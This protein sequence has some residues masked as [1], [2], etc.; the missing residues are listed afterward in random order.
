MATVTASARSSAST[1]AGPR[2]RLGE[3]A[4]QRVVQQPAEA[5]EP[6][7]CPQPHAAA[8]L[9]DPAVLVLDEPVN[10]LDPEGIL[11]LRHLV[12]DLA[13][14]GR[15]VFVS[16]HLMSEAALTV[17][18]L[19]IIGRGRLLADTGMTAFIDKYTEVGVRV[20]TPEPRRLRDVLAGAGIAVTDCSDGSLKVAAAAERIGELVAAHAVTVHE[21]TRKTVSLEKAFMRLTADAVEYRA[22][23]S[24][25]CSTAGTCWP[26]RW[27][28][29]AARR[30]PSS[31]RSPGRRRRSA[32]TASRSLRTGSRPRLPAPLP[33]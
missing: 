15:T 6:A 18:H 10:G 8:L 3:D 25:G 1:T 29:S 33:T 28:P 31:S 16:S 14:Q 7:P 27:P 26:A 17:D 12:R 11:W 19:V 22:E 20:R 4:G 5:G 21:V 30:S 13:V 2:A 9:G 32:R 24:V 23:L